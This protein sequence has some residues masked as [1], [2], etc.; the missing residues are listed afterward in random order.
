MKIFIITQEEAF[1]L[2]A[3]F[4]TVLGTAARDVVGITVLP[5]T[6]PQRGWATTIREHYQLYGLTTFL[7]QGVRFAGYRGLAVTERFFPLRRSYSVS[8]VAQR[9]DVPGYPTANIN[10]PV[11]HETLR[12]LSPDV[13]VSVNAS[14]IFKKQLLA[15]PRRGCI[16]VHGALL[17]KYRGRLPSFWVLLNRESEAGVTVHFM[18]EELDGGPII[19]QQRVPIDRGETQHSLITKTKQ[20]GAQLLLESLGRLENGAVETQPNDREQ[21]TVYSFPTIEDGRQFRSLGLRFV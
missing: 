4:H 9:F 16:N 15:L 6:M 1:Y 18:N 2:P 7:R 3:F 13:I 8:A 10:D 11:Y 17:P 21:A 20:L 19:A 14:Q 5:A 12:E